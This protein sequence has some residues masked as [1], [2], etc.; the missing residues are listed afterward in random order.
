MQCDE[1]GVEFSSRDQEYA[2][3]HYD[4]DEY[5]GDCGIIHLGRDCSEGA[6]LRARDIMF[7]R[8][9]RINKR[10]ET[11]M[12]LLMVALTD[13]GYD[14]V[15]RHISNKASAY[16]GEVMRDGRQDYAEVGFT[17]L[18]F[19]MQFIMGANMMGRIGLSE[20]VADLMEGCRLKFNVVEYAKEAGLIKAYLSEEKYGAIMQGQPEITT[21]R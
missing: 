4:D 7:G 13:D 11:T 9:N 21:G 1:C 15:M 19:A 16:R 5:C 18:Y 14:T 2:C 8:V 17:N 12:D 3:P 6:Y 20:P 10:E